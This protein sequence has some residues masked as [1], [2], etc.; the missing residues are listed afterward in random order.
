MQSLGLSFS[1]YGTDTSACGRWDEG[2]WGLG[3][4]G[5]GGTGPEE[6][7]HLEPAGMKCV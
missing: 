4:G 6:V 1:F 3:R 2:D 5:A 7:C